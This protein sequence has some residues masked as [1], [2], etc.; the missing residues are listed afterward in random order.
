V[1]TRALLFDFGGTLYDYRCF[2]RAELESLSQLARWAGVEAPG[3]RIARAHRDAMK[4]VFGDYRDRSFYYHRDLFGDAVRAMLAEFDAAADEDLL[5]RYRR[6]QWDCHRRDFALRPLVRETLAE[7]RRRGLHLGMVSNIDDDQLD[8]LLEVAG[9][10]GDFDAVLSSEQ[11]RSCKPAPAIFQQAL[12]RA[13]C[14]PSEALF[15]G[16]SLF[17]DVA[18]ANELGMT[19]VLI[20]HSDER[21]PPSD[22]PKP[23]HVIRRFPE[24]LELVA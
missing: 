17:H 12:A 19:S 6:F 13:G 23:H 21:E 22:G 9:V 8:H 16:D 2:A 4:R 14:A 15:V 7:L 10:R 20:W 18:G 1:S 5:A 24:L 11:A 3:E